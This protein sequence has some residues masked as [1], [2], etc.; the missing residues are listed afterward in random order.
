VTTAKTEI[1]HATV[2]VTAIDKSAR[3]VTVKTSDG[4]CHRAEGNQAER[5]GASGNR[6]GDGWPRDHGG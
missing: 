1:T 6:P 5:N 2:T 4:D 3:K